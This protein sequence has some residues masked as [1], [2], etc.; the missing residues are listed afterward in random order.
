M[1][2]E[3][4]KVMGITDRK[5]MVQSKSIEQSKS[6]L[7]NRNSEIIINHEIDDPS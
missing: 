5:G 1:L 6:K 4:N 7:R 2:A 3:T